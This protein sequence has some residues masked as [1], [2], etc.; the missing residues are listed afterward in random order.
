MRLR[1]LI[2]P[3]VCSTFLHGNLAE[4]Q[5]TVSGGELTLRR[6]IEDKNEIEE[7]AQF[8][9]TWPD[10]AKAAYSVDL[11]LAWVFET[12]AID[13]APTVEY[14]RNSTIDKEQDDLKTGV[15]IANLGTHHYV[16]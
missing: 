9:V 14:H 13:L 7:A 10:E 8:T 2:G 15:S 11:G 6:S 12:A 1:A 4:A 16:Q 5:V 3:I